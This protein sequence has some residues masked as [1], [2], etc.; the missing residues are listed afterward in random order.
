MIHSTDAWEGPA[1]HE[2]EDDW[3]GDGARCRVRTCD[4]FRVKEVL[5]R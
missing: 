3:R 4:P 1:E 2:D 5:Y